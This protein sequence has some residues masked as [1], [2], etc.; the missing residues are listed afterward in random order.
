[1]CIKRQDDD[2]SHDRGEHEAH[3]D[4]TWCERHA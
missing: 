3:D 1:M 4:P 2:R